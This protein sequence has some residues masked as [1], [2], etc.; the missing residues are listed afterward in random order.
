MGAAVPGVLCTVLDKVDKMYGTHSGTLCRA[1][2]PSPGITQSSAAITPTSGVTGKLNGVGA[3]IVAYLTEVGQFFDVLIYVT[4][5]KRDEYEQAIAMYD[6][7][8]KLERG[9]VYSK[10]SLSDK[11]RALMDGF[12]RKSENKN[13]TDDVRKDAKDK[14]V[15]IGRTVKSRHSSGRAVDI[16]LSSINAK[17]RAALHMKM[18]EVKEGK[19]KD[20]IHVESKSLIPAVDPKLKDRWRRL[21]DGKTA[22]APAAAGVHAKHKGDTCNC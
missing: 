16:R 1:M 2:M 6:N 20:I 14:F 15:A 4:S 13:E 7:W 12:Y 21:R 9:A 10:L 11:N 3:D 22:A 18:K 17:V 5:G 8:L 19:R